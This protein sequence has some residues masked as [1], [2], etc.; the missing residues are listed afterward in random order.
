MGG[1]GFFL[2]IIAFFFLYF[3]LVRPQKRR[4]L[5]QQRMLDDLK[6]G[7]EIV[8]AGGIYGEVRET[9]G[10]D[11]IVRIAPEIEVRVARRAVAGLVGPEDEPEELED[12][13]GEEPDE[14]EPAGGRDDAGRTPGA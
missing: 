4:Q 10:D 3:V 14:L 8:T 9:V 6:P 7:D 12:E 13:P 11:L 5:A 2:I 1:F